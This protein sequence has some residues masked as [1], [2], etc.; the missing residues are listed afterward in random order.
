MTDNINEQSDQ[1]LTDQHDKSSVSDI[2]VN[3]SD[4]GHKLSPLFTSHVSANF[5]CNFMPDIKY[6]KLDIKD[7]SLKPR[8]FK[9]DISYLGISDPNC[10][11]SLVYP[12]LCFCDIP[13]SKVSVHMKGT[14]KY[15]GYGC[16]GIALRKEFGESHDI[17][18]I[19]YLNPNSRLAKDISTAVNRFLSADLANN[20]D[21]NLMANFFTGQLMY[22]KPIQGFM[23][24]DDDKDPEERLFKDEC[25]WR[26]IPKIPESSDLPE[27][28]DERIA[29]K[30][31]RNRFSDALN[32]LDETNFHFGIDDIV[33]IIVKDESSALDMIDYIKNLHKRSIDDKNKLISKIEIAE[34]FEKNLV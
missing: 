28:M 11:K 34:N 16:Y 25:E 7:M 15:T 13:L 4:T 1:N 14:E 12:M 27:Y 32:K 6:L 23:Q 21:L 24:R 2:S 17:Q 30:E 10:P 5:L 26:Y 20:E 3:L 22:M 33:Y 9:E 31:N 29:S 8:Y 19:T 18:P